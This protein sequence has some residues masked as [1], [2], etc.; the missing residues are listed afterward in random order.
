M[1]ASSSRFRGFFY[2]SARLLRRRMFLATAAT[3]LV[4]AG[5]LSARF[6]RRPVL[7]DQPVRKQEAIHYPSKARTPP[8]T[9]D[10]VSARLRELQR[11]VLLRKDGI[12]RY[13]WNQVASNDPCEDD[14]DER[15]VSD[16]DEGNWYFWG[17]YD[18]HSGWNTSL[19]LR[20]HLV[21]AVVD[22]LKFACRH[23]AKQNAC[24]T[25]AALG[26]CMKKAFVQVDDTI[27]RDHVTRV[28]KGPVSLQQAASL[29]LPALSGSCALLAAYSAKSQN[30]QVAC[31]GDSRAVLGVRS[32]DNRG[33]ETVPMSADQTGAN[34]SEAERLQAEHPGE[35][36]LTNNRILGR[37]MPSRAFGDAKYKWTS[38]VA[39]RLYREY[40]ALRPL[41]TKTPPYVTAEPVVQVQRIEPSRQSFLILATDGLWDTMS[42]ERAVQLV[43]EWIESGQL[44]GKGARST[45]RQLFS[46]SS[47][48]PVK[49]SNAATHLIRHA[50]GGEDKRV[51]SLLTLTY[52]VS[53]RYRDDITVTVVF[54][55][56]GN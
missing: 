40:F 3:T 54:F 26:D 37:L 24:P 11:T 16:V 17:V 49:D 34:P 42:S 50:L 32:K 35:T 2:E 30:L 31:T 4:A 18:G 45:A 23:A 8:K 41:P 38:E 51:S 28:F 55:D 15:T 14:H 56:Y 20:D 6:T 19:F 29:L 27:V 44:D 46:S 10:E 22:E 25:P 9:P 39:A 7:L 52:P 43:G 21:T 1:T 12:Y 47:A 13:D 5:A 53:R 33:W 48:T 36:V